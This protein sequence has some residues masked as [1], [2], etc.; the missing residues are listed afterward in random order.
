MPQI[1]LRTDISK[2]LSFRLCSS[3][4]GLPIKYRV[5]SQYKVKDKE[6][7]R[8]CANDKQQWYNSKASKAEQEASR[9]DHKTLYKIVKE[10]TGQRQQSQQIKLSDGRVARTHDELVNRWKE[11]FEA[12]LNCPEPTTTLA[13]DD[14]DANAELPINVNAVSENEV[15]MAIKQLKNGKAAGVDNI[16]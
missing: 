11:H 14:T 9:G 10:L 16:Q 12:V 3:F 15:R 8:R 6:V 7:K 2:T 4:S 1:L 13:T 5:K